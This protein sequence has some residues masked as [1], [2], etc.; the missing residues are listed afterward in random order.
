VRTSAGVPCLALACLLAAAAAAAAACGD[1]A[2][3]PN[4]P[5]TVE[6]AGPGDVVGVGEA[7]DFTATAADGDGYVASYRFSFSDGTPA[8]ITA[9]PGATHAFGAAGSYEVAVV[10]T[11]DDGATARAT[12]QVT[13]SDEPPP[14][15]EDGLT[16]CGGECVDTDIDRDHCGRCGNQC[17]DEQSCED[18]MCTG[19]MCPGTICDGVC[20]DTSTD[21]NN[22][23]A[24]GTICDDGTCE[25]GDCVPGCL[26][27]TTMCP[28]GGCV[29]LLTDPKNCGQCGK[30][31]DTGTCDMGQCPELPPGT[32]LEVFPPPPFTVTRGLTH[33]AGVWYMTTGRRFVQ[34]DIT[35]GADQGDWFIDDES[36]RRA[37]GLAG[38][39]VPGFG[40]LLVTGSYN[41][42]GDPRQNVRL[43]V[44]PP[45]GGAIEGVDD[46]GGPCAADGTTL[47]VFSNEHD[48]V[49]TFDAVTGTQVGMVPVAGLSNDQWFTDMAL[50][51]QGGA[52]LTRPEFNQ[53]GPLLGKIDLATGQILF[54]TDPPTPAGLG[55]IELEG[56]SLW[57]V[58]ADGAYRMVP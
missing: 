27:P 23:G 10:V 55:G 21:P 4:Q 34:I 57:G 1:G 41:R 13:V 54:F 40:D 11:D 28:G 15:C 16:R 44:Y 25:G 36:S 49:L 51:G 37:Y 8:A 6:L 7:V 14:P 53:F 24:C 12:L 20:V 29:D 32:V 42:F 18:G 43:E 48:A 17:G 52:W 50:D 31:C 45:F 5:P 33:L 22:C 58:A 19:D 46:L 38:V 30:V 47:Y 3:P 2:G 9:S 56:G 39:S 26:P 35:T